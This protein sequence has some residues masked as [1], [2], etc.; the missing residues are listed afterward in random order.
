MKYIM[1]ALL[2]LLNFVLFDAVFML[3]IRWMIL[4]DRMYWVVVGIG[5]MAL[6]DWFNDA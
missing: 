5:A 6:T 1:T 3:E 2:L 4:A